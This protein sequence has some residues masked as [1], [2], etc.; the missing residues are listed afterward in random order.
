MEKK[1][2]VI[3]AAILDVLAQPVSPEVFETGSHPVRELQMNVGGDAANEA[4]V[5]AGLGQ[6][7]E[8]NTVLGK[9]MA[10]RMILETLR[11]KGVEIAESCCR[12]GIVTGINT[13]LIQENGERSFLTNPNGSLRKLTIEDIPVPFAEDIGILE[14]A[15]IFVS[16]GLG[17]KEM[18]RLF[19]T[20]KSQGILVCADMTKPKNGE[21]TEDMAEALCWLDYF[22][23]NK[24]EACMLTRTADAETAAGELIRAGVGHVIV[25]CGAEGCIVASRKN[26]AEIFRIPAIQGVKCVDTTGAGDSFAAGFLT[27]LS[28]GRNLRQ[29]AEFAA[30]CGARAVT[31]IGAT[32]WLGTG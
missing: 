19:R 29:C 26:P 25:K 31:R 14:L 10:G 16:P 6:R 7:V 20:A 1:I 8:I 21:R 18:E 11:E 30:V 5:L 12:D 24:E 28:E 27:A 22:F 3:G 23:P 2:L 4:I 13:V 9:D 32:S 15:S 17:V